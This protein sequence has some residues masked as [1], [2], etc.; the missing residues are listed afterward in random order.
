MSEA[1]LLMGMP[2]CSLKNLAVFS[3]KKKSTGNRKKI[4]CLH[5][6]VFLLQFIFQHKGSKGQQ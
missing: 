3:T 1:F 2:A 5:V 6:P 4:L